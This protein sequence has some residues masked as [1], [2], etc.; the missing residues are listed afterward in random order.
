VK[1]W[2]LCRLTD[3]GHRVVVDH[4]AA[5]RAM[6]R[7]VEADF[8]PKGLK[9]LPEDDRFRPY[10]NR[11]RVRH[12]RPNARQLDKLSMFASPVALGATHDARVVKSAVSRAE[13]GA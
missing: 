11:D 4:H 6:G 10:R 5:V 1:G 12:P 7:L 8:Q 2:V 13:Q 3:G 9:A